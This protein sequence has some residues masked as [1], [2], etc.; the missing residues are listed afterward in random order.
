MKKQ[1]LT[2]MMDQSI[3]KTV[4]KRCIDKNISVGNYLEELIKKEIKK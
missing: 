4:K 1:K 3:I 2:I